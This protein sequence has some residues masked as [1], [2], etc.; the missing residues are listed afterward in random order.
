MKSWIIGIT[1]LI[2]SGKSTAS[3]YIAEKYN[4]HLID[5]D[6]IGHQ[7]LQD[8]STTVALARAF[9]SAYIPETKSINRKVLSDIVFKNDAQLETL[10]SITWP[11][12]LNEIYHQISKYPK[13][14]IEAIGLFQTDLYRKCNHTIYINCSV[15]VIQE[16]LRARGLS[17]DKIT[18][19]LLK[20]TA[21]Q[22][23]HHMATVCVS[24]DSSIA[25][26]HYLLDKT[27]EQ[28]SKDYN[29]EEGI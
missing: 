8:A 10:Q 2:A 6:K 4:M 17:E 26:M 12:I 3:H 28:W 25:R 20:Q 9:P 1:G 11:F 24:N 16:R 5:A 15:D 22:E 19:I 14:V 13:C 18:R 21:I 27:M 7:A 29:F 23:K